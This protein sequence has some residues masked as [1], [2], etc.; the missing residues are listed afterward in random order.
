MEALK[1]SVGKADDGEDEAKGGKGRSAK[2]R[3][4]AG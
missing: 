1:A 3:A 4:A 2:K